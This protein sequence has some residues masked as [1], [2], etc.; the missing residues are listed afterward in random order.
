MYAGKDPSEMSLTS[1]LFFSKMIYE[2]PSIIYGTNV[3]SLS[4]VEGL[5][6]LQNLD[7]DGCSISDLSPLAELRSLQH[8]DLKNNLITDISPLA[9]LT[10]L[11]EV[12]LEG[13]PVSDF[14]PLLGLPRL[15]TYEFPTQLLF[16]ASTTQ[17]VIGD[18][19]TVHIQ[20][21]NIVNLAS[22]QFDVKFD[23]T[24]IK[25]VAV[26]EGDFLKK[27]GGEILFQEGTID[28]VSGKINGV[29]ATR[30]TKG[31]ATGSGALVSITFS[32]KSVGNS[33]LTL[34]NVKLLNASAKEITLDSDIAEVF[35]DVD[36]QV[37][38]NQD[39]E[40]NIL[41]LTSI[42]KH[43]GENNPT[44]QRVDVNGDGIVNILDL[45]L[46]AQRIG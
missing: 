29:S 15:T 30:L 43:I 7:A 5:I 35:I 27:N 33:Q 19:F 11:K 21:E 13:N 16:L 25:S 22:W 40:I 12:Y 44:D 2:T 10:Q 42:A 26:S 41:D 39:G 14:T 32:A 9:G 18:T 36:A 31:G 28:N 6:S 37:D 24:A 23:P 1:K 45:V 8:L 20:A 34:E 38:V 46:V 3:S 4:G 17:V